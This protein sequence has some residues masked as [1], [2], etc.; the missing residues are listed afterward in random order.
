MCWLQNIK[1]VFCLNRMMHFLKNPCNPIMFKVR[2]NFWRPSSPMS[3]LRAVSTTAD[4][5]GLCPVRFWIIP[6]REFSQN[7][8][9]QCLI[10]LKSNRF[11][12][13]WICF[14]FPMTFQGLLWMVSHWHW[15]AHSTCMDAL[16]QV[17]WI[18]L[19]ISNLPK[20]S[21]AWSSFTQG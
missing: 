15:P 13:K 7:I 16:D 9:C 8:I 14:C 12:P 21:L 4:C 5:S 11:S 18:Y 17:P 10:T 6:M 19:C 3:L 20:C 2:R 1:T